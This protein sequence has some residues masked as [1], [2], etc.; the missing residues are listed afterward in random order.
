MNYEL[1]KIF[2]H[3]FDGNGTFGNFDINLKRLSIRALQLDV[4]HF[5]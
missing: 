5:V 1:T 3:G 4:R 2:K